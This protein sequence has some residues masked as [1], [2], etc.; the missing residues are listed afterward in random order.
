ML[1]ISAGLV[2]GGTA[3]Y[4]LGRLA[5]AKS[6]PRASE[7]EIRL[8]RQSRDLSAELRK[9]REELERETATATQIPFVVKKLG[10]Q[11]EFD[12][13]PGIAVRLAKDLLMTPVVVY[14]SYRKEAGVLVTTEGTG[15]P[16]DWKGSRTFAA[17][18]GILGRALEMQAEVTKEEYLGDRAEWPTPAMSLEAAGV[19]PD[20]VA[21]VASGGVVRGFLVAAG[22]AGSLE[23]KRPFASM[24]ADLVATA[25][26]NA[27]SLTEKEKEAKTDPLTGLLNRGA[28][29]S[30]FNSDMRTAREQK[31]PLSVLLF[32]IDHFRK[33]NDS[34]GLAAGD[35]VLKQLAGII[36]KNIRSTDLAARYGGGEFIVV[37]ND[38]GSE[39]A[40]RFADRL[41]EMISATPFPV[42]GGGDPVPITISI[43]VCSF[44]GC[45]DT[46]G[47]LIRAADEALV[48]AKRAG[49]NRV[50]DTLRQA[51]GRS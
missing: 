16:A 30:R 33:V 13:I 25:L 24:V 23:K 19:K 1:H 41:R 27:Y 39:R 17:G 28:F 12:A 4:L 18:V 14:L 29:L 20:V 51:Q 5:G 42:P 7:E 47:D 6:A 26:M 9:T 34:I 8:R 35:A 45:G 50:V 48:E 32:D 2:L 37:M 3:G 22:A 43:G 10:E 40:Y 44:P 46:T 38:T 21:P 11:L 15:I 31:V 36:R 49:R